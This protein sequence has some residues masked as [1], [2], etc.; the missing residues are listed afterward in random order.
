MFIFILHSFPCPA[1]SVCVPILR[2]DDNCAFPKV[3]T[4]WS[5]N[6]FENYEDV[7]DA[8]SPGELKYKVHAYAGPMSP[9]EVCEL[10]NPVL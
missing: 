6:F 3:G 9:Q 7:L 4:P 1:E 5:P 10:L 8:G 2:S